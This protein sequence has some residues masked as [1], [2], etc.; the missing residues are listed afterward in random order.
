MIGIGNGFIQQEAEL[1]LCAE[2]CC[3]LSLR[4]GLLPALQEFTTHLGA[5]TDVLTGDIQQHVAQ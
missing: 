4:H 3:V 1:M 5:G 2:H